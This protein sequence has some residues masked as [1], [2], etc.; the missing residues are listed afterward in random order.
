MTIPYGRQNIDAADIKA[1]TDVLESEYITQG[2]IVPM[3]ERSVLEYSGAAF[4]TAVSSATAALHLGCLALGVGPGDLVW[5]SAITFVASA[6]CARYCGADVDFVDIDPLSYNM[7]IS[8]LERK[9]EIAQE[10]GRLPKVVIPVHLSGQSCD[11]KSISALAGRFGFRVIEDASHAIGGIYDKVQV[12]ACKYSD[13]TVF[14]FHAVKIITTGEGGMVV[15]NDA[16]IAQRIVRLRSHGITRALDEVE[17]IPDGPWYYEQLELGFNYRMNDMQA[18]LGVSQMTKLSRFLSERIQITERYNELLQSKPIQIPTVIEDATSS[19]HLFIARLD[20][21]LFQV[22]L[23]EVFD[24]MRAAGILVN[25]HY[26]PVYRHPYYQ[27]MGYDKS[28]F[29]VA[30]SYYSNAISLPIYPGFTDQ[31]QDFVVKTLCQPI[32]HQVIF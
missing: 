25:L 16:D 13:I 27:K 32:G 30:E 7:S 23:K 17:N 18:A 2:P 14:S 5:T 12:G 19:W 10:K 1:V 31:Q 4:A 26:I 29:P 28:E 15:T 21:K 22:S 11:M 8:D 6:N 3:F 24:R 20:L 9:L